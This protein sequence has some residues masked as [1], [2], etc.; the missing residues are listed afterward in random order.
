MNFAIVGCGLIGQKR[1]KCLGSHRLVVVV[2]V[3]EKR[4]EAM[5]KNYPGT[6]PSSN[7]Q[8]AVQ[9]KDVDAV[10]V[11]TPHH[12]L[13]PIARAAV[14]AGKHVL[15]EKPGGRTRGELLPL[16][17]ASRRKGVTVKVGFNHRFHP[18]M[19]RL[20]DY[21]DKGALGD[22][23]FLR[24][25][26]GHGGR[27]GY[28]KEWRAVPEISGGGELLDQGMHL[29]DLA[30]W[31]LG[32]FAHV[33]GFIHT[34]FWDMPVDDNAFMMLRTPQDQIAWLHVSWTEWKNMFSLELYGKIGKL[35]WEGLGGSYGP[36]RL[37]YYKMSPQ[38][39]PPETVV[40]EFPG[41]D[42]SW[43]REFQDFLES[44]EHHRRPCGDLGD[45][46]KALAV[47]DHLYGAKKP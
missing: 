4:A 21:V 29:I 18:A 43:E 23:M 25:R 30:G 14:E 32:D 9:R 17:E 36:E 15:V 7:W 44:M 26:Y 42:A 22:L 13:A 41:P 33:D 38:M 5:A 1:A 19:L 12:L 24:A 27:V 2:D 34:Y 37:T 20:R 16:L 28:E 40:H 6:A 10:F 8:E 35:H 11:C 3:D 47:V 31:V 39:G 46:L 45:A